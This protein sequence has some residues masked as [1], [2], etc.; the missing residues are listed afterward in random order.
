MK[1]KVYDLVAVMQQFVDSRFELK[2]SEPQACLVG[3][4]TIILTDCEAIHSTHSFN[5]HLELHLGPDK[6]EQLDNG[7][8]ILKNCFIQIPMRD[9]LKL[10]PVKSE[11]ELGEFVRRFGSRIENNYDVLLR[12]IK[13]IG[14]NPK[15]YPRGKIEDGKWTAV[16]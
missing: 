11:M 7:A 10:A 6:P 2:G 3:K 5:S 4:D 16:A 8:K 14:L 1:V 15:D 12:S 13:E 9:F